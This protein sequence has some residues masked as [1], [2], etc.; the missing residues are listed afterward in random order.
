MKIFVELLE[1]KVKFTIS[2][3]KNR[4]RKQV[5]REETVIYLPRIRLIFILY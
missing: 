4:E 2:L 1:E 5:L 3:N